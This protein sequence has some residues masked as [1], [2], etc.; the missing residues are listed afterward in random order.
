MDCCPCL[1]D[2]ARS[3]QGGSIA[4]WYKV[5]GESP[6]PL[7]SFLDTRE[8]LAKQTMPVPSGVARLWWALRDSGYSE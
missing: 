3:G 2:S 7:Y 5:W 6:P 1:N 8:A 4:E